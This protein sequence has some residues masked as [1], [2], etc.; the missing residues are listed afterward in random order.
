MASFIR[1][2]LAGLLVLLVCLG[3]ATAQKHDEV[4]REKGPEYLQKGEWAKAVKAFEMVTAEQPNNIGAWFQMGFALH[5]MKEYDRAI[6]A[7]TTVLKA[8]TTP[9][10]SLTKYNLGCA[11]ALKGENETAIDWLEKAADAGFS[12]I[13]QMQDDADLAALRDHERFA[14]ILERVDRNAR[15]CVYNE[16]ARDLD[17][18]IGN[19]DV[20]N[21]AGQYSGSNRVESE[22]GECVIHENWTSPVS[23]LNGQ[24]FSTYDPAI[25]KWR[26]TWVDNQG[27]TYMFVGELVDGAMVFSRASENAEGDTI[28]TRMTL[29][30]LEDGKIHQFGQNSMDNGKTWTTNFD[31]IYMRKSDDGSGS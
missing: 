31:L 20:Y 7:Y 10:E 9:V 19:W 2:S 26:Q 17:F 1:I 23:G 13:V 25:G 24:S 15:P 5:S 18:W 12:Q 28:L 21:K 4:S 27:A 22:L 14:G 6:K 3:D 8:G 29:A 30:P 16:R 11:Y